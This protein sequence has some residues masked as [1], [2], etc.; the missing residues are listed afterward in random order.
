MFSQGFLRPQNSQAL[1]I[2]TFAQNS[3]RLPRL[4]DALLMMV[5]KNYIKMK[6]L[7]T[8]IVSSV[9]CGVQSNL[10]PFGFYGSFYPFGHNILHGLVTDFWKFSPMLCFYPFR[11]LLYI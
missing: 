11:P 9:R 5:L 1:R 3:V 2:S 7:A 10:Q 8:D 4:T 6:W